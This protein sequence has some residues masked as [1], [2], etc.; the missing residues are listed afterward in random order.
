MSMLQAILNYQ[1]ADAKLYKMEREFA[2]SEARKENVKMKKWFDAAMEK[3]D[4]YET[5]ALSLKSKVAQLETEY[6]DL[7]ERL[8]AMLEE[9]DH[10]DELLQSGADLSFY[11][12]KVGI[13]SDRIKKLKSEIRALTDEVNATD[14]E[15]QE[16]KAT[17]IKAEKKKKSVSE[18]YK[19]AKEEYEGKV[20]PVK[21]ELDALS[22][23]V[24]PAFMEKYLAK[25]KEKIF[26]V[27]VQLQDGRCLCTMELSVLD[28]TNLTEEHP[29]ECQHCNR[30][31]FK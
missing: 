29:I 25:R 7:E 13:A 1:Q 21:A 18:A 20:A 22:K 19:A 11:K 8:K 4:G 14:K 16:F 2:T 30:I 28:L 10:A 5:K 9:F 17:V 26:P 23:S 31:I 27:V 3:L 12:K 6:A 15:Y 24:Q